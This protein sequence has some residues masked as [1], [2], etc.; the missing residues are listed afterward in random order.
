MLRD[1]R[2]L[3]KPTAWFAPRLGGDAWHQQPPG[4]QER[5]ARLHVSRGRT[6][7]WALLCPKLSQA[8]ASPPLRCLLDLALDLVF[9]GRKDPLGLGRRSPSS[10]FPTQQLPQSGLTAHFARTGAQTVA[11]LHLRVISVI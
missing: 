7:R 11:P 5:A 9:L 4:K 10:P 2:P 1:R 3:R 8:T 6:R